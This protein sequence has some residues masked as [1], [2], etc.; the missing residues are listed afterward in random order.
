MRT[1]DLNFGLDPN[2]SK[3]SKSKS[4]VLVLDHVSKL[5][6]IQNEDEILDGFLRHKNVPS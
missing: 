1:R 2:K 4:P 6:M 5:N 3:S